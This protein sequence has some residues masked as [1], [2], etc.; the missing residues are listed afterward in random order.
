MGGDEKAEGLS[1]SV[2]R[3]Q[4]RKTIIYA[5]K[6][7]GEKRNL[8]K[9]KKKNIGKCEEV[10]IWSKASENYKI[11]KRKELIA[12]W[13]RVRKEEGLPWTLDALGK[14]IH[15]HRNWIGKWKNGKAHIPDDE[16][17]NYF[18]V[19]PSFFIA[20]NLEELDLMNEE[21]H[22]WM[23]NNAAEMA[24]EC[25]VSQSFLWY[26]KSDQQ[27]Q[28]TIIDNQPTDATLNS[29]DK[30]VPDVN[31]PYQFIHSNG[32]KAY[33]NEYTFPLLGKVE[34][35]VKEFIRYLLWSEYQKR[36]E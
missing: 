19:D 11:R 36:R 34:T 25:G 4:N 22:K 8:A 5:H 23:Q 27:L 20:Q 12:N 31:S 9:K 15:Y 18:K 14:E 29:F 28:D 16:I 3:V 6:K 35:K 13:Q 30:N 10:D 17:C 26:L 33:L 1:K 24:K 7:G 21:H 2:Q 32:E